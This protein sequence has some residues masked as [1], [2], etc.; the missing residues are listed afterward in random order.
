MAMD[1]AFIGFGGAAYGIAKGLKQEGI[2][3][4]F[5]YTRSWNTPPYDRVIAQRADETGAVLRTNL[6]ELAEAADCIMSCVTG[7]AA[8][9]VAAEIAPYLRDRHLYVDLNTAEPDIKKTVATIVKPTGA[10]F[11]DAAMMGGI[12]TFL[13]KVPILASGDGAYRVKQA[14]EPF[15][16][17]IGVIGDEPGQAAAIKMF[18]SI[19]MKGMLALLLEVMGASKK[20]HATDTVLASIA[21]TM[22]KNRFMETA[23]RVV[24][25]GVVN[26]ER[27]AREMEGV[28]KTLE[29]L[30]VSATMSSATRDKLLWC[31]QFG[32]RERFGGAIPETLA[33]VLEEL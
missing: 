15:G 9:T 31:A 30:S 24:T 33:A 19:F 26:P 11:V 12:P 29:N 3:T 22:D 23:R 4:I 14:F 2:G 28:V 25:K 10:S 13:H 16:M 5:Y 1:I 8:P 6:Q 32:L 21:E 18:R 27:M 20:Y 7:S 17:N